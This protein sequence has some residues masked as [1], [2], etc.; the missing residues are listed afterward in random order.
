MRRS[1]CAGGQA[2]KALSMCNTSEIRSVAHRV[3]VVLLC[4]LMMSAAIAAGASAQTLPGTGGLPSGGVNVTT[5][6]NGVGVGVD[7]GETGGVNVEA[8]PGGINVGVRPPT[9]PV[10]PSNPAT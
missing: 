1:R 8:G 10:T 3:A 2:G 6:P 7:A 9:T 5:G 4:T